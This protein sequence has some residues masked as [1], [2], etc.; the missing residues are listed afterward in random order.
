MS[1]PR[2]SLSR[3]I[4]WLCTL[5]MVLLATQQLIAPVAEALDTSTLNVDVTAQTPTVLSGDQMV[6][7]VSWQCASTITPCENAKIVIPVPTSDQDGVAVV[8]GDWSATGS[9]GFTTSAAVTGNNPSAQ[10]VWTFVN[11]LPAGSSGQMNLVLRS[12]NLVTP[13]GSTFTPVA[14]FT[15]DNAAAVTNTGTPV[16]VTSSAEIKISK[17]RLGDTSQ[18]PWLDS[19][20]T[21]SIGSLVPK[22]QY[23]ATPPNGTVGV[24]DEVITDR[25]PAGAVFVAAGNGGTY[26]AASN[27]VSWKVPDTV[28]TYNNAQGLKTWVTV[29]YPSGVF[30][31]GDSVTNHADVEAHTLL[32]PQDPKVTATA[33]VTEKLQAPGSGSSVGVEVTKIGQYQATAGQKNTMDSEADWYYDFSNSGRVAGQ[34]HIVDVLPCALTDAGI[35][36][37]VRRITVGGSRRNRS[38]ARSSW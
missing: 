23:G 18:D 6:W 28:P 31:A 19:D 21:Y 12:Q 35:P 9:A 14:T 13:N 8:D 25:L 2:R 38:V 10:A 17:K 7:R 1:F 20:I 4:A 3:S 27:T 16:T 33:A 36:S 15:A 30:S 29:R 11:P 26:D 37:T 22:T 34:V 5:V 32:R 24:Q